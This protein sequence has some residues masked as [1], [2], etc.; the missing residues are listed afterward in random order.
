MKQ[1]EQATRRFTHQ[2]LGIDIFQLFIHRLPWALG[3]DVTEF[4]EQNLVHVRAF[5]TLHALVHVYVFLD[6][7]HFIFHFFEQISLL[8]SRKKYLFDFGFEFNDFT[9]FLGVVELE[10]G[11]FALRLGNCCLD[12]FLVGGV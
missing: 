5:Q 6:V 10:V 12:Q 1:G 3:F 9:L 2:R 8:V 7:V 11:L 4:V